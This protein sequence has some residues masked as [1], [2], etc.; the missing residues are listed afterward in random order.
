[1]RERRF[2]LFEQ[3]LVSPVETTDAAHDVIQSYRG[4]GASGRDVQHTAR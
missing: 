4:H 1:M 3:S 2:H